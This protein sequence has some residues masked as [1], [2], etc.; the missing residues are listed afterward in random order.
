M[1]K[2]RDPKVLLGP[3][4]AVL[5][6]SAFALHPSSASAAMPSNLGFRIVST[7]LASNK[8]HVIAPN[9]VLPTKPTFNVANEFLRPTSDWGSGHRGVD[10]EVGQKSVVFNPH[11]GVISLA[12][13]VFAVPTVVVQHS[14]A[15]SSVFQPVCLDSGLAVGSGLS[16]GQALGSYC[17]GSKTKLHCGALPCVH[18]A[19]RLAKGV[20]VNPLRMVGLLLP[21]RLRPLSRVSELSQSLHN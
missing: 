17:V 18:W 4:I 5:F 10:F 12:G 16:A 19:F 1:P 20:Y 14:D 15:T 6:L 9:W 13:L 21:S 8:P 7:P 2:L 3:L 11:Q